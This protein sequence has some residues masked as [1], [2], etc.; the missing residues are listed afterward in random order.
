MATILPAR[1]RSKQVPGRKRDKK[2]EL[3]LPGIWLEAGTLSRGRD[4]QQARGHSYLLHTRHLP[5]Q[6][7]PMK[8]LQ[9]GDR[10][11]RNWGNWPHMKIARE[12]STNNKPVNN[13]T[14]SSCLPRFVFTEVPRRG[15][16]SWLQTA[17]QERGTS[18][19]APDP[20]LS[21]P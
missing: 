16:D 4:T 9:L 6:V 2:P 8:L 19:L 10:E 13:L 17:K 21:P 14:G 7:L 1:P 12:P 5:T 3:D 18:P 11:T 20:R 15:R